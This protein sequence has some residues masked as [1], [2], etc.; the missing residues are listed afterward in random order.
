MN[1]YGLATGLGVWLALA[2]VGSISASKGAPALQHP[3]TKSGNIEQLAINYKD[4]CPYYPSPVAC[5]SDTVVGS[6]SS[7]RTPGGSTYYPL[8]EN[9]VDDAS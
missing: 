1:K 5:G 3:E 9:D 4:R 6:A 8:G 7:S 2:T